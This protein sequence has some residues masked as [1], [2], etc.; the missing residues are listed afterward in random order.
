MK[1]R[2][3][4]VG[5]LAG[6]AAV[7][8]AIPLAGAHNPPRP[9]VLSAHLAGAQECNTATPAACGLGDPDGAGFA[10]VRLNTKIGQVC[11]RLNWNLIDAPV[12]AHIHKA[13]AGKAGPV[14]VPLT[15]SATQNLGC[16]S[17]DKRLVRDIWSHPRQYYV[18]IHTAAYPEGAVRGQLR[19]R[20]ARD[21]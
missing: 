1:S 20:N 19:H 9:H 12:A 7:A 6:L 11:Y 14:V 5:L 3:A 4:W 21:W 13:P 17:A 2:I 16:V 15:V 18:N 10:S 8:L